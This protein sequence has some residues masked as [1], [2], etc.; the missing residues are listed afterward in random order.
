MAKN[1]F[2]S[3]ELG[4]HNIFFPVCLFG[5][6]LKDFANVSARWL[7]QRYSRRARSVIFHRHISDGCFSFCSNNITSFWKSFVV[8][9]NS[10]CANSDLIDFFFR[11]VC[12][13]LRWY[14]LPRSSHLYSDSLWFIMLLIHVSLRLNSKPSS[15]TRRPDGMYQSAV[16]STWPESGKRK[17]SNDVWYMYTRS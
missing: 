2:D 17:K 1:V 6:E 4:F 16:D 8:S 14:I 13:I 11:R 15:S 5:D 10:T 3:T 12:Y 7:F 9:A